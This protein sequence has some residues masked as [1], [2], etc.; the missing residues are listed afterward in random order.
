MSRLSRM[1][2]VPRDDRGG[3][4]ML[5]V[6]MLSG[7]VLLGA[8]ALVTDVGRIYSERAQ[9]Q[10]GADAAAT[11]IAKA[12]ARIPASCAASAAALGAKYANSNA[13]D[14][15]ADAAVIC[16]RGTG[17]ALPACPA[18]ATKGS[19]CVVSAPASGNYVEVRTS[20]RLPDGSTLLPPV[21]AAGMAG[22][23]SYSGSRVAACA[24]A[25]WGAPLISTG[26]SVTISSCEW[27]ANTANG[28]S[29][30]VAPSQG[31]PP[32]SMERTIYLHSTSG[33]TTCPAGPSGWDAPGGFGWLT[34]PNGSCLSP[35]RANGT[36]S[37]STGVSASASCQSALSTAR[38]SHQFAYVPVYDG[39]TGTGSGTT[40]HLLGIATFV[41]TGYSLSS[42]S[43]SSWLTGLSP[44]H[45]SQ[46]CLYGY[47][48]QGLVRTSGT[49]TTNNLGAS[50]VVLSG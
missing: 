4:A 28:T 31:L 36:F 10:N 48:T 47:F 45:G 12:C 38:A 5:T 50:I 18:P 40:Y 15:A 26:L 13:A 8:G 49:L 2:A 23:G 37:G 29:F 43:A 20:T 30:A 22:N 32:A 44:C 35:I 33:A 34:E 17:T 9:L 6:V 39:V 3:I 7:G 19:T 21:L 27:A 1:F 41:I 11:A 42:V 24:R 14:G 46:R 16:G 25:A